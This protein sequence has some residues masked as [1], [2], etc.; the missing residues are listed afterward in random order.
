MA[1]EVSNKKAAAA[2]VQQM[3][4]QAREKYSTYVWLTNNIDAIQKGEKDFSRWPWIPAR[5]PMYVAEKIQRFIEAPSQNAYDILVLTEPPQHGKSQCVTE[6]LPS[7]YMGRHPEKRVILVS[8]ND[9]TAKPF[10]R[11]NKD[12]IALFGKELFG[13]S[14]GSIDTAEEFELSN[15]RGAMISRGIGSGI[16]GRSADLLLIDDPIKN[17]EDADSILTR[18]KIWAEWNDTLKT[19]LSAG[20][21]VIVI[22]TRWHE[23][24]LAGRILKYEKPEAVTLVRLPCEAEEDDPLG[25]KP[26]EALCP[27]FGKDNRWLEHYKSVLVRSEGSRTWNALFQGRP[28][29][30]KGNILKRDWWKFYGQEP[31]ELL[32]LPQIVI[33]VDAAFDDTNVSDFVSVQTWGKCNADMYLL[34]NDT[35]RMD[36][37]ATVAA[38]R[39]MKERWPTA[40]CILIEKKANGSAIIQTLRHDMPGVIGINPMGSKVSRANAVS[41]A[42]EAGNVFLPK[43]APWL[44]DFLDECAAF[45]AGKHDDQVDAMSQAL[46]RLNPVGAFLHN[47]KPAPSRQFA[48]EALDTGNEEAI[49]TW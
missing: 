44:E 15:G 9:D 21:K 2:V 39:R 22:M 13:V 1:G 37:P 30:E 25:R 26:G 28:V 46:N 38:I 12:K 48:F 42:I 45:P 31:K 16:T 36:F 24:D 17:R 7:W 29:S 47:E 23:D 10:M 27:E 20:A 3:S 49:F 19:R 41:G 14:I 18:N 40:Y 6:T 11:R 35:R 43:T 5:A 4:Q 8:Y 33:S 34:D 32:P